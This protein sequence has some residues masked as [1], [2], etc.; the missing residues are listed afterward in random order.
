LNPV[1]HPTFEAQGAA[2]TE[3]VQRL[4][5]DGHTSVTGSQAA[6]EAGLQLRAAA[7]DELI[8]WLVNSTPPRLGATITGDSSEWR[9]LHL[10]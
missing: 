9:L 1:A 4:N 2:L 6:Q 7:L 8:R 5:P 3:A 10:P